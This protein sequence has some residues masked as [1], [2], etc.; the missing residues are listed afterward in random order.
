MPPFAPLLIVSFCVFGFVD[1]FFVHFHFNAPAVDFFF[2]LFNF[3][4]M[5]LQPS[6]KNMCATHV[7]FAACLHRTQNK[8]KPILQQV[9]IEC[10]C[11]CCFCCSLAF[12]F[13]L[14]IHYIKSLS[15]SDW[16][17]PF[18]Q[19]ILYSLVHI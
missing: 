2:I 19:I 15:Y 4:L 8:S 5:L 13:F 10:V 6:P 3:I 14:F 12:F 11:R 18:M 7:A 16:H 1:F 9:K 17:A